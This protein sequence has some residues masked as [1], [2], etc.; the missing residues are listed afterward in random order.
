MPDDKQKE[1]WQRAKARW[2][3]KLSADPERLAS[4]NANRREKK[5]WRSYMKKVRN[6]PVRFKKHLA[7]QRKDNAK[8]R[9][10]PEFRKLAVQR[11]KTWSEKYPERYKECKRNADRRVRA[12]AVEVYGGKCQCCGET[13]YLFLELDHIHGNGRAHRREIKRAGAS[14]WRWWRKQ[15]WPPGLRV[16]CA[17][18]HAAITIQGACPHKSA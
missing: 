15:G 5:A 10:D 7:R 12:E 8:L 11:A 2:W 9:E 17:N 4:F 14:Y 13:E 6:D 3:A 1:I 16:L 18:C